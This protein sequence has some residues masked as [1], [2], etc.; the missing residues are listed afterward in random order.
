M[1]GS[2][3]S[4]DRMAS[5]VTVTKAGGG[6]PD[7]AAVTLAATGSAVTVMSNGAAWHILGRVP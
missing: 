7:N 2:V 6:G 1:R 4:L 5:P 3:V